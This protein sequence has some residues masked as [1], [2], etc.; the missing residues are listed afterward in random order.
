MLKSLE[1][2][3]GNIL[4]FNDE[5]IKEEEV[6]ETFEMGEYSSRFILMTKKQYENIFKSKNSIIKEISIVNKP[7]LDDE[8]IDIKCVNA[9]KCESYNSKLCSEVCAS[10]VRDGS[11]VKDLRNWKINCNYIVLIDNQNRHKVLYEGNVNEVLET[12]YRENMHLLYKFI[13]EAS[14]VIVPEGI[15]KFICYIDER[16][17]KHV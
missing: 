11:L 13:V 6:I 7:P 2:E 5:N 1:L 16:R 15:D 17:P 4:M 8:K 9:E 12:I 3:N 10:Y 14:R